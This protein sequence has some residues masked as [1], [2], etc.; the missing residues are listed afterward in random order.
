MSA[1]LNL[2]GKVAS[3]ND[4]LARC[5]MMLENMSAHDFSNEVGM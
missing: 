2:D 5:E 4:R 3:V 1:S